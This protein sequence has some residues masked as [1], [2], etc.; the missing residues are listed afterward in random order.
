MHYGFLYTNGQTGIGLSTLL[1]CIKK[2]METHEE[3]MQGRQGLTR[4]G[5]VGGEPVQSTGAW[6]SKRGFKVDY[7]K[8]WCKSIR[9]EAEKGPA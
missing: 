4:L 8:Q 9:A 2:D 3:L 6:R 1:K 5:W 7:V